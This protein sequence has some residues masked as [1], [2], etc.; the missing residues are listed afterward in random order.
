VGRPNFDERVLAPLG[1][2]WFGDTFHHHKLF[3]RGY[4]HETGRG[5]PQYFRVVD[6]VMRYLVA[7]EP[8]GP[9]P[10]TM[11][12]FDYLRYLDKQTYREAEI[13][14]YTGRLLGQKQ[15]QGTDGAADLG[16][17]AGATCG[18]G[19]SMG[20]RNPITGVEEAREFLRTYGCDRIAADYGGVLTLRSGTAA[21][22]DKRLDSGT[23]NVSG[24]RSGCR[25]SMVPACGVLSL[26]SWTGNCTCNYPLYTSLA[27][28]PMPAQFEQWSAWGG[29]AIEAPIERVGINF[30]APGDRA[31]PDGTL[32][33]DCPSVGGP[34]PNVPVQIASEGARPYY[35]HSLGMQ[36]GESW[37]WVFASG[38][39]G[40]R[41]LRIET[42]ARR[43]DPPGA[44]FSVRWTGMVEPGFSETY[45]F[46]AGSDRGVRVWLGN[47]PLLD[48]TQLAGR[49]DAGEVS[50]TVPLAAGFKYNLLV[51][52][53]GLPEKPDDPAHI[54]LSWSSPSAPK[55]IVPSE[56]LYTPEGQPGGLAGEYF[57]N[58]Q[59]TGPAVLHVDPRVAFA[60]GRELPPEVQLARRPGT[61][62][63][64][65]YTVRLV[66]AEPEELRPG[67]RV[68]SVRIQGKEVLKDFDIVQEAGACRR[69]AVREFRGVRAKDRV[70]IELTPATDKP[71]VISGV[72]LIA[73][74]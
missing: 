21:F 39:E 35:R 70:E 10:A 57:D 28:A 2:L 13:D 30:G 72:E 45:T 67:Q 24:T 49:R 71:P 63:E 26:P 6:G 56:R 9:N 74:G 19:V 34:S 38:V 51:E 52:Y 1:L 64:R 44:G 48:R 59:L 29:V 43:S 41:Q 31:A 47:R 33:L 32:W 61:P 11:S 23:I 68:F 54:E 46:S 3:Y 66:F 25:N 69:G 5:L 17:G 53:F 55:Q 40:A 36:G 62:V 7:E 50:A 65:S 42:V 4:L 15:S 18:H 16:A 12:Y 14:V 58:P 22:Y 27:M 8:L 20:R 60:W 37:P 73:E